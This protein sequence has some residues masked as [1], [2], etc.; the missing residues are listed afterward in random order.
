VF[1]DDTQLSACCRAILAKAGI[2]GLWTDHGPSD[3]ALWLIE[4]D[5]TSLTADQ[6][7]LLLVALALWYGRGVLKLAELL[8]RL[9]RERAVELGGLIDAVAHGPHAIDTWLDL[10]NQ[11]FGPEAEAEPR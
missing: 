9:P 7:V 10:T 5:C 11:A 8:G 3:R 2:H 6:R 4:H 1:R